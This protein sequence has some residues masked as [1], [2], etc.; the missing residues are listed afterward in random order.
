MTDAIKAAVPL[1][2]IDSEKYGDDL[3]NII[4]ELMHKDRTK[5]MTVDSLL[6][7]EIISDA[8]QQAAWQID[9]QIKS[10]FQNQEVQD[11]ISCY[12]STVLGLDEAQINEVRSFYI[13]E[14]YPNS[15]YGSFANPSS[16]SKGKIN[17]EQLMISDYFDI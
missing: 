7:E 12:Q 14:V 1:T 8:D 9:N 6:N 13:S 2:V 4:K 16:V 11:T 10:Q 15:R 3:V 17:T 5:R